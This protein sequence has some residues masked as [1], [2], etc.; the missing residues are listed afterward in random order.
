[1]VMATLP[2]GKLKPLLYQHLDNT[3]DEKETRVNME[4]EATLNICTG[5]KEQIQLERPGDSP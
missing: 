5:L 3:W 4:K 2:Y 1:M